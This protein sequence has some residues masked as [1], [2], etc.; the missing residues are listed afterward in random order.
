VTDDPAEL[1]SEAKRFRGL[2]KWCG[3]HLK[4]T[5]ITLAEDCERRGGMA[6]PD[7]TASPQDGDGPAGPVLRQP[8]GS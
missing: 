4:P 2:A 6:G 8:D 3:E 1:G 7:D 5:L